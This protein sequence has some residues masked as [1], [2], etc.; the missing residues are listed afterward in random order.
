MDLAFCKM[1]EDHLDIVRDIRNNPE[2]SKYMYTDHYITKEE[3]QNW[4][5]KIKGDPSEKHWVFQVDEKYVGT[6]NLY[7]I[8][9]RNRKCYWGYCL[10]DPS[11]RG[12]G[13]GR[14]MELNLYNFGFDT[15]GLNKIC[16]EVFSF[17]KLGVKLHQRCGSKVE[18]H[19][20]KHIFKGETFHDIVCMGILKEDWEE[21][22]KKFD[23]K[24]IKM[25]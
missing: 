1:S 15:L 14:L 3:H 9:M 16:C 22:K 10:A 4:F 23:F 24:I 18:G 20:R 13:L 8:D 19:F 7:D 17:N 5:N 6:G 11:L 25:E 21:F 2:V 12:K